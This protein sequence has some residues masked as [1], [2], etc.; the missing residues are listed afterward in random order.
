ML[1]M[2]E[3]MIATCKSTESGTSVSVHA[4]LRTNHTDAPGF[5]NTGAGHGNLQEHR[6][7]H[8]CVYVDTL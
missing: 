3:L 2:Q 6:R 8:K 7:K 1:A 4:K 5:G